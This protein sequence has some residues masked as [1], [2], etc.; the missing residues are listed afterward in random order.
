MLQSP[1]NLKPGDL[2]YLCAP[3]KATEEIYIKAAEDWLHSVGLKSERSQ[4]IGGRHHYFSGSTLERLADLQAGLDHPE[5]KAIWCVRGG[6]GSIQLL[7]GLQ[8]A[9]F[10][11]EPKWL[12]GFSDICVLHHKIQSLGFQSI[13]GTMALNLDK[14][15]QA[16]KTTLSALLFGNR[17]AFKLPASSFNKTG[18]AQ[19]MLVG[20]NLSIVFSMLAT[21]ERYDFSESILF[22]EDLAEHLYHID[23]M[24]HALRKAG[25]LEKIQGLIIGGMTELE[26]TDVPFGMGIEALILAHFQYRKIPI[27]FDF[28]AGHIADNR[29]LVLG[30][31]VVLEVENDQVQLSYLK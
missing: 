25:A 29:A 30:A 11:R 20:G 26:D 27:C 21:P 28:P 5:A 12:I 10:I 31:Q 1:P 2:V 13:H 22:I 24:L 6:Y 9:Q 17:T 7:D 23:R 4:H 19:G 8:W 15:S 14:N 18:K 16:A 3:A